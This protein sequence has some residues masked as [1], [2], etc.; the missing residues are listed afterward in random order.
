MAKT[1]LKLEITEDDIAYGSRYADSC[2]IALALVRALGSANR[3]SM[4]VGPRN[5][6][7]AQSP[8]GHITIGGKLPARTA[9][10]IRRWDDGVRLEPQEL[11]LWLG[12]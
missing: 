3:W 4:Q 9:T 1:L 2:P 12:D 8:Q 6:W 10:F 7:T 11:K 5:R